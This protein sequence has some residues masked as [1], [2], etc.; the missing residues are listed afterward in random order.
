MLRV[1]HFIFF[2]IQC[3]VGY[4]AKGVESGNNVFVKSGAFQWLIGCPGPNPET[5]HRAEPG[6]NLKS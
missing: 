3:Q 4:R 6:S 5:L 2:S 1:C